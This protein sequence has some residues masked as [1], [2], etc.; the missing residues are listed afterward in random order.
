MPEGVEAGQTFQVQLPAVTAVREG[1][2]VPSGS[3]GSGGD[4]GGGGGGQVGGSGGGAGGGG[5]GGAP[6]ALSEI[7]L[8]TADA[9]VT[10]RVICPEGTGAGDV[11]RI[12]HDGS[13]YVV[14]V[15]EGTVAGQKF[16]VHL[17]AP[18]LLRL[19]LL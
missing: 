3:G 13:A 19:Y 14:T 2:G 5:G 11:M 6:V 1:R 4:R 15:P 7:E 10:V 17:P 8:S 9:H 18:C 12:E 16:Q